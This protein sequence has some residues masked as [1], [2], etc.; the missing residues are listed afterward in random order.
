MCAHV[1]SARVHAIG[2]EKWAFIVVQG[3]LEAG[4]AGSF[5]SLASSA[6]IMALFAGVD[7]RIFIIAVRACVVEFAS[8]VVEKVAGFT[9]QAN[10][11][12][13]VAL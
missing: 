2:A 11:V 3:S 9:S 1:L 8:V 5:G 12:R 10:G 13:N 4:S 7:S 6:R